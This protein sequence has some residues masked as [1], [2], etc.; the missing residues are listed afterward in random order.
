MNIAIVGSGYV[1]L[2]TGVCP[3]EIG[4]KVICVDIDQEKINRLKLG[5]V[6]IYEPGLEELLKKNLKN[7]RL[8]FSASIKDATRKSTA[9]F[10]AVGTPSKKNGDADLTY[11][12]NVA[13]EIAVNMDDY[14]LIIKKRTG[15]ADTGKRVARTVRMNLSGRHKK[16]SKVTLD[17]D[18]ASNPEFLREGSAVK[19]FMNPDRVVIGV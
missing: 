3:A 4:H 19:D 2:V 8:S 6:P 14:K 15:P 12:E 5:K 17:F 16:G 10:I 7:K 1:G 18:V 13:R 11:V 9:I